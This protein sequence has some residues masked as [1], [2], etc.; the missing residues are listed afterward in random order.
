MKMNL[1]NRTG[2][3]KSGAFSLAEQVISL[4]VA[5]VMMSGI[6][7]GFVQATKQAEWASYSLAAQ[8]LANQCLEQARA[9]KW[10]PS[11]YP[12]VDQLLASNFP[13]TTQ[14]LDIP[15]TKSNIVYAT[16][17]VTITTIS[18]TPPLRMIRVDCTWPFFDRGNFSNT[19]TSYRAADQ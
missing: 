3:L 18:T 5:L 2:N 7:S 4:A 19:V 14:I 12:P 6:V 1:R 17:V 9:A 15:I 16:N 11:A 8:S 13:I 10:D